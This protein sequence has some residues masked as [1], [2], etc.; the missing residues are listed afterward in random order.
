ME[1]GV[2]QLLGLNH[3]MPVRRIFGT[4][5]GQV[6]PQSWDAY[7]EDVKHLEGG[8]ALPWRRK[9]KHVIAVVVGRDRFNPFGFE[10][11]EV[12]ECHD[13]IVCLDLAH[14]RLGYFA[15]IEAVPALLLDDAQ[16]ASQSGVPDNAVEFGSLSTREEC[17]LGV[18]VFREAVGHDRQIAVSPLGLS[19]P[20]FGGAGR[21]FEGFLERDGAESGKERVVAS[22]GSRDGCRVYAIARNPADS[23]LVGEERRC[24]TGRRPARA[25]ECVELLVA[26]RPDQCKEVAPDACVV[27]GRHIEDRPGC[28]SGIH[29]VATLPK[30]F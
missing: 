9:L 24:P 7:F 18:R 22:N 16:C 29:S 6:E 17:C 3:Q 13:S 5:R 10:G 28:D 25:V 4:Q 14:D 8:E 1:I 21:A 15:S 20:F 12:I 19:P 2:G 30:D 23:Q 27:L 11:G 26:G